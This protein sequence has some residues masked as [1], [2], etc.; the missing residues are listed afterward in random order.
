[1]P[2]HR[3]AGERRK[4]RPAGRGRSRSGS[5]GDRGREHKRGRHAHTALSAACQHPHRGCRLSA[6]SR[7]LGGVCG[8]RLGPT[9]EVAAGRSDAVASPQLEIHVSQVLDLEMI[10]DRLRR[11]AVVG[12][13]APPAHGQSRLAGVLCL[14]GHEPGYRRRCVR[15]GKDRRDAWS[16]I[17]ATYRVVETVLAPAPWHR[18]HAERFAAHEAVAHFRTC[19]RPGALRRYRRT[20]PRVASCGRVAQRC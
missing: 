5:Q 7:W 11:R 16:T 19:S 18:G 3:G 9:E 2:D 10:G 4:P 6:R 20:R 8:G 15:R 17:G 13:T 14:P 1:M 12:A